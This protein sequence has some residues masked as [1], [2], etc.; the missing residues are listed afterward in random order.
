MPKKDIS[1][2]Y[3]NW[4]PAAFA[5][6][7]IIVFVFATFGPPASSSGF[8]STL[9]GV[10]QTVSPS[11]VGTKEHYDMLRIDR[12]AP[13]AGTFFRIIKCQNVVYPRNCSQHLTVGFGFGYEIGCQPVGEPVQQKSWIA[14]DH[15]PRGVNL[16]NCFTIL[17]GNNPPYI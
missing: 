7:S 5:L 13:Q 4:I 6:A 17:P 11:Y 8:V 16:V 12:Q 14:L 1:S 15:I 9:K 3:W 2:P 10:I